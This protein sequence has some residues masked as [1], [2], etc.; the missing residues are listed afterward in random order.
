MTEKWKKYHDLTVSKTE[1]SKC[2]C[3]D[4]SSKCFDKSPN[5][6]SVANVTFAMK[7]VF[8]KSFCDDRCVNLQFKHKS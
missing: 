7:D 4:I 5:I 1:H 6:F 2:Q 3:Q 8:A